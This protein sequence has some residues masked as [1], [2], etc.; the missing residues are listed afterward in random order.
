MAR[1]SLHFFVLILAALTA[2]VVTTTPSSSSSNGSSSNNGNDKPP[3]GSPSGTATSAPTTPGAT[4]ETP[5]GSGG[6]DP[7]TG[8][9][10]YLSFGDS[11]TAGV[12]TSD[13]ASDAWPALVA[14]KWRAKA[15]TVKLENPAVSGYTAQDILSD[16]VP[17]IETFKPTLITL[18]VGANDIAN[19][20]SLETYR[21]NV[22]TILKAAKASGARVIVI[23]QNEWFRSPVGQTYGNGLSQQ[24]DAYDRA[25]IDEA[26]AQGAELVDLRPL[27]KSHADKGLWVED[28]IHPTPG[29]YAEW[30][31]EFARVIPSPCAK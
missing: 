29:A 21:A 12:G 30:A 20:M 14:A 27:F 13:P 2:C 10:R 6:G 1:A 26:K 23:P 11:L 7:T 18:Q 4:P 16:Q 15:C 3:N 31:T 25:L 28:G 19:G 24:R 17:N 9:V 8:E 22:R 5:G